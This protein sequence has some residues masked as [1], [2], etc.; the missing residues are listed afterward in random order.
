MPWK[1]SYIVT[2]TRRL[3]GR[4]ESPELSLALVAAALSAPGLRADG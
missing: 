3:G 2:P 4:L 1:T